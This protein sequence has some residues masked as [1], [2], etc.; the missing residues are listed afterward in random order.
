MRGMGGS[1]KIRG[2]GV[3][4]HWEREVFVVMV[5]SVSTK[6]KRFVSSVMLKWRA[7][8]G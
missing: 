1:S 7:A 2:V 3:E 6:F 5:A 4:E 8:V